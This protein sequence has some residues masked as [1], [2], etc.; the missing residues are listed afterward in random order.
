MRWRMCWGDATGRRNG[1]RSAKAMNRT[2][3]VLAGEDFPRKDSCT[4]SSCAVK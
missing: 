4:L 1:D 3:Q 2:E